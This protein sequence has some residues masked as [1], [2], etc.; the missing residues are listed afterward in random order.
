MA[1]VRQGRDC[2]GEQSDLAAQLLNRLVPAAL[3]LVAHAFQAHV[4]E[5]YV[6]WDGT[7]G[8]DILAGNK[9]LDDLAAHVDEQGLEPQPKSG[10]QELLEGLINRFG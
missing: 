7:L 6:G 8:K 5:R 1:L 4:D 2:A 3:Q 10:R 9:S